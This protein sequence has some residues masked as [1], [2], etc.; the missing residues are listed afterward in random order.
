MGIISFVDN[1]NNYFK[2]GLTW[3]VTTIID[4]VSK[5]QSVN[6]IS[7]FILS[8]FLNAIMLVMLFNLAVFRKIQ[9]FK[10][11]LKEVE[12]DEE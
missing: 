5:T 8:I 6:L 9:V 12:K 11:Q 10:F 7:N 4:G 2:Y 1:F 3:E